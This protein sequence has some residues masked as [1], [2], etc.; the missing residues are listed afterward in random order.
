MCVLL[1]QCT[2]VFYFLIKLN[3]LLYQLIE[4]RTRVPQFSYIAM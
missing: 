1:C 3:T 4:A 2:D